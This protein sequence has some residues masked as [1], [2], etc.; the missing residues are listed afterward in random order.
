MKKALGSA[1]S[2]NPRSMFAGRT[3][4]GLVVAAPA[5]LVAGS[6]AP[7]LT[8]NAPPVAAANTD[9]HRTNERRVRGFMIHPGRERGTSSEHPFRRRRGW[10]VAGYWT[11]DRLRGNSQDWRIATDA[12]RH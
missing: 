5:G 12:S 4:A 2:V 10:E 6:F 3:A 7:R 11:A 9:A 1:R 8:E